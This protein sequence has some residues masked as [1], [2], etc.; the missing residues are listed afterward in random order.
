V[1]F[2]HYFLPL[3]SLLLACG[4]TPPAPRGDCAAVELI[5]AASDYSGSVVCG[6]PG[7]FRG[8]RTTGVALGRDPMLSAGNGR[9]FFLARD[10]DRV[11]EL[12]GRCGTPASEFSVH[13]LA[14]RDAATGEVRPANPHDAAAAP[15]GTVVLPLYSAARLAFVKGGKLDGAPLDL[16][17][18][19]EDGN[20]QAEAV[21]VVDVG[22]AA[23][24]FVTLERLDDRQE[25][26]STRA[27]QML[28]VDIASRT[29]DAAIDLEGRNPFNPMAELGGALFIAEPGNF[30]AVSEDLAGIER[31]ETTTSATRLLVRERDLRA[32]V[33]EVAVTTGCGA[34]IV[35]T[36]DGKRNPTAVVTFDP[37]SGRIV[38][39]GDTAPILGPT[40][41]YDLQGLAWRGK[42]LYV[43]DRRRTGPGYVVHVLEDRGGCAVADTGRTIALPD[44][45][46]ALRPAIS[47][48]E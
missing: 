1:L 14:T 23:K 34:A 48:P 33:A 12:D 10:D 24:A 21:R 20:P 17:P 25:L 13:D 30:G 32:S 38:A 46:V 43:G 19:D 45:P 16:A 8:P 37:D 47:S 39:G 18:W 36:S 26:R 29:V 5:V 31:F 35:A 42:T 9:A 28:V 6:A 22:G 15:D 27:S 11:F 41:D 40:P 3:A 4:E 7:C 44:P 2:L